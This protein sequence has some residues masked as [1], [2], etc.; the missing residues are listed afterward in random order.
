[1]E[2]DGLS[3]NSLPQLDDADRLSRSPLLYVGG[4]A[5]EVEPHLPD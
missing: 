5:G 4:R 1:M 3:L 2:N